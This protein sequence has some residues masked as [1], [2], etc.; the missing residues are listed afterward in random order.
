MRGNRRNWSI[1]YLLVT[2]TQS[3][4]KGTTASQVHRS[5]T[6]PF[7]LTQ[8]STIQ[9]TKSRAFLLCRLF[10]SLDILYFWGH[11]S[12]HFLD[13]LFVLPQ[14][15]LLKS[16][17]NSYVKSTYF[18]SFWRLSSRYLILHVFL[19]ILETGDL[20]THV[21]CWNFALVWDWHLYSRLR[22]AKWLACSI[23]SIT[24]PL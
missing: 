12:L 13:G 11:T 4:L 3:K 10:F 8:I 20:H 16:L 7:V 1:V 2:Y 9:T 5:S 15:V 24:S 6:N 22:Y 21:K 18:L 23:G 19:Q 17:S 14:L